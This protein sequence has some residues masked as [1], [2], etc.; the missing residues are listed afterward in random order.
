MQ[1]RGQ[2]GT[3]HGAQAGIENLWFVNDVVTAPM[4]GRP[5]PGLFLPARLVVP[6]S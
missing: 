4:G 3:V 6:A 1:F 5:Q 2:F